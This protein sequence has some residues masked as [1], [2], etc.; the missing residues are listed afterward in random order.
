MTGVWAV[1]GR[2][3]VWVIWNRGRPGRVTAGAWRATRDCSW[4]CWITASLNTARHCHRGQDG[5]RKFR[6]R[7]PTFFS[8]HSHHHEKKMF[9]NPSTFMFSLAGSLWCFLGG[10]RVSGEKKLLLDFFSINVSAN[11]SFFANLCYVRRWKKT[12]VST[13]NAPFLL[14]PLQWLIL[15]VTRLILLCFP[16]KYPKYGLN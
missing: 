6:V 3:F 13:D 8:M 10:G 9:W 1:M 12:S 2:D 4:I 16:L 14:L 11:N 15:H 5:T 7:V